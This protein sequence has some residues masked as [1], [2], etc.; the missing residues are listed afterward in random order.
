MRRVS[1]EGDTAAA[2]LV[3]ELPV[4]CLVPDESLQWGRPDKGRYGFVPVGEVPGQSLFRIGCR[5]IQALLDALRNDPVH[6][7]ITNR[8]GAEPL[9]APQGLGQRVA[10]CQWVVDTD[11]GSLDPYATESRFRLAVQARTDGGVEAVGADEHVIPDL[12]AGGETGR[13][14]VVVF[15]DSDAFVVEVNDP[16]T[17][18]ISQN[19][20]EIG[21]V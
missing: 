3:E 17:N 12:L 19:A 15:L 1:E 10:G 18:P 14:L 13:D 21:P 2:P 11:H 16:V 9:A 8:E 6:A 20:L 5:P 7:A 4:L